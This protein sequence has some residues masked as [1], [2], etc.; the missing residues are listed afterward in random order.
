MCRERHAR[1]TRIGMLT[2]RTDVVVSSGRVA[3]SGVSSWRRGRV[4]HRGGSG[5]VPS[6]VRLRRRLHDQK[7]RRELP[8]LDPRQPRVCAR[9]Q[10]PGGG[11]V[12]GLALGR[13]AMHRHHRTCWR[14]VARDAGPPFQVRLTQ[15][16]RD[17]QRGGDEHARQRRTQGEL[18]PSAR[19]CPP[20]RARGVLLRVCPA[21]ARSHASRWGGAVRHERDRAGEI[22][23]A[24][25]WDERVEAAR[26]L[27]YPRC[28]AKVPFTRR[29]P[30][31]PAAAHARVRFASSTRP[32]RA[33]RAP[34][35]AVP[36]SPGSRRA[37]RGADG[38]S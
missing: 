31:A 36:A 19:S 2:L 14:L 22:P 9:R 29:P 37:Q 34:R 13:S 15:G 20:A 17:E 3:R 1:R 8:A 11:R 4:V 5:V 25:T 30:R 6:R 7:R 21:R 38:S 28:R 27:P 33:P 18:R 24:A 10:P 26:R 32:A 35:R 23:L 12:V 16:G